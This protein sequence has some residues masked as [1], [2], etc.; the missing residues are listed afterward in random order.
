MRLPAC[1]R[2][3]R[4]IKVRQRWKLAQVLASAPDALLDTHEAERRPVAARVLGL[5]TKIYHAMNSRSLAGTQRGD[6]ERQLTLSYAGG[7]LA[8][9]DTTGRTTGPRA[10]DRAP[11]ARYTDLNGR[12]GRLHEA[13]RGPHFT[14][15]ALGDGADHAAEQLPWPRAG[16]PL[17][18]LTVPRPG[19][20]LQ[21]A[22]AVTGPTLVLIRPHGH[23]AASAPVG[24]H[25]SLT[26][27]IERA[28]PSQAK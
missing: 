23:I 6:E 11:D 9:A 20:C 17:H 24:Q 19:P 4:R 3:A 10:G 1:R 13:Y 27:F 22:Y 12:P 5:S 26:H 8:P 7:P 14:L 15:L 2:R 25:T 16:A 28:A 18:T 21:H